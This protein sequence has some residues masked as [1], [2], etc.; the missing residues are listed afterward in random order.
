MRFL[1]LAPQPFFV[2]RGT[3]IATRMLIE[4]L[5]EAGHSVHAL[6]YPEGEDVEI[7]G[8][9]FSR[10]PRI[11]GTSNMPPGFSLKKVVCDTVMFPKAAWTLATRRFDVVL[12]IEES[13]FM[14]MVLRP[15]FRVP[16][17]YDMDSSIPEQINDKHKLPGWLFRALS[18]A[19]GL[20]ARSSIGAI[21]CCRALEDLMREYAPKIPVQTLEDVTLIEQAEPVDAPEDC[22]FA[23][24]VVMYVGNL[25]PYQGVD[26]LIDGFALASGKGADGRLVII[27]GSD[28]HVAAAK[29]KVAALGASEKIS[30]LGPRP[31]DRLGEYLA[32]ASIV[33]SPRTQ[34]RNTPMKVYSYLDSGRPLL[35]TRLPTHTQVLDDDIAMLVEPT[36]EAMGEGLQKLLADASL[37]SRIAEAAGK[38]VREEF[39]R[40]AYSRKLLGFI[41]GEIAPRLRGRRLD[42]APAK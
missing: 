9:T 20:A 41:D 32:Q 18:G 28:D 7:S 8:A 36:P 2:H 1:I 17:I 6:V 12:A 10:V 37:R 39:S 35:A 42:P 38:R 30:L 19:E 40:D 33:V 26:L 23:E 13:A 29:S 11:P 14:A 15:I 4:T 27:G 3:P 25:E 22:R 24:P 16:Y 31:V 21:T 5:T 34:G